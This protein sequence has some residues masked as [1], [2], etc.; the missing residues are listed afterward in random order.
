MMIRSLR[1]VCAFTGSK[2]S[3]AVGRMAVGAATKSVSAGVR[4]FSATPAP[5]G[6]FKEY[7]KTVKEN[8]KEVNVAYLDQAL[9][10]VP[11]VELQEGFHLWMEPYEWNEERIPCAIYFGRGTLE[12]DIEQFIPDTSAEIIVYCAAGNRSLLAADSLRRLGYKNVASL[13]GGIGEW[14]RSGKRVEQNFNAYSERVKY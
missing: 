10:K 4:G 5:S 2:A 1:S 11:G 7:L 13:A 14:R 3:V 9:A 8:V 12:R 6:L